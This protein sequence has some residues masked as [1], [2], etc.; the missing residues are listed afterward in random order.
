MPVAYFSRALT[1]RERGYSTYDREAI[2][3]RDTLHRFRH[4]LLG[5]PFLLRTDH[6]PL[7]YISEMKDPYGRRGR[8]LADIQEYNFTVQHVRG[9]GN[10]LADA[11][12]RIGYGK[13]KKTDKEYQTDQAV[14]APQFSLS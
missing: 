6:K 5:R 10:S 3:I 12:S 1:K 13:D 8:L 9:T 14:A 7:V 11:L 2:A 4:Y